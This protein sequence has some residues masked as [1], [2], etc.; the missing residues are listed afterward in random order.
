MSQATPI[1]APLHVN[2]VAIS[3][4]RRCQLPEA[5]RSS[6]ARC[7]ATAAATPLKHFHEHSHSRSQGPEDRKSTRLNSSHTV[8]SYAV[9]CLKKKKKTNNKKEKEQKTQ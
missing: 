4:I 8:I 1:S 9:F 6:R 3:S 2:A 5:A 7:T